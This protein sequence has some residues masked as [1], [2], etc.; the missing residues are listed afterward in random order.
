M[1][2]DLAKLQRKKAYLISMCKN[3]SSETFMAQQQD[4]YGM[5]DKIG[6]CFQEERF[7]CEWL[8]EVQNEID[9]INKGDK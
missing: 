2:N 4:C 8:G 6:Q 1:T 3:A 9:A 7:L 5:A